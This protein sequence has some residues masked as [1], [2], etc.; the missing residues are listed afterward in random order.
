MARSADDAGDEGHA[1]LT[2]IYGWGRH[3]RVEANETRDEDLA[4]ASRSAALFR[5]LGRSYGDA[6]LPARAG[7]RVVSTTR[8]DRI[9]A[10][11]PGSGVLRAEA[12]L[13]LADLSRV[14]LPRGFAAP[15]MP[16]TEFVTLGGMVACDVHGKNHHSAGTFGRHVRALRVRVADGRILELSEDH[17]PELFF[18]TQGGLGLTC[19]ILEVE[20]QL[21]RIASPWLLGAARSCRDLDALLEALREESKRS[22]YTVAWA[23]TTAR[24]RSLGRGVVISGDWAEP[25]GAAARPWRWRSPIDLPV[26]LPSGLVA[27]WSVRIFNRA[28]LSLHRDAPHVQSP[29]VFFF[30]LDWIGR[31]NRAYGARGFVQYQCVVPVERDP[32]IVRRLFEIL[33]SRGVASPVLVVKDFVGESRGTLSFPRTGI[34]IALDVPMRGAPTQALVDSLNDE[35]AAAGGRIYLA[36]DALTRAEHFRAMET[37]LAAWNEIRRKWDP[38]GRLKSALSVRLLGD[39]A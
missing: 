27:P 4:E 6:S 12:G 19:Q 21:V 16:G 1:A 29:R 13:S 15:V 30:P 2:E 23:D 10:F 18:A 34:S 9:L 31:W 5:G 35:V 14:F 11:D 28:Y 22:R 8:A 38:Q 33:A 24:G 3:P 25:R 32:G 7:G 26:D 37:R 39:E 17:E 20:V 36:K